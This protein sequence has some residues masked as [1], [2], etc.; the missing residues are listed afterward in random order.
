VV[1]F[2]AGYATHPVSYATGI[3]MHFIM[4]KA[5]E[6]RSWLLTFSVKV[7][8]GAISLF[9]ITTTTTTT[10][11]ITLLLTVTMLLLLLKHK[12]L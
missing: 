8:C 10:T 2:L 5:A 1:P 4:V 9:P 6:A 3:G 12:G 7:K 11:T